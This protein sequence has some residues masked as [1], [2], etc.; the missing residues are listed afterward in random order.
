PPGPPAGADPLGVGRDAGG[1]LMRASYLVVGGAGFIGGH[2]VDHLLARPEV[3]RV[4][5]YDNF[6]SGRAWHLEAHHGSD[7]CCVVRGDVKDLEAL[8]A[9]MAGHDAVIHLASNPDIARAATEPAVDFDE[10][11]LLT[12]HVVEAMRRTAT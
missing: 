11:T 5:V 6:S 4:T 12:H 1:P 8:T 7:R 10:G 2:F 9:A 3:A